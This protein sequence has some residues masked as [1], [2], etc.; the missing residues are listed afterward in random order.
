MN[1]S[2]ARRESLAKTT[3]AAIYTADLEIPGALWG[4]T[5]RSECARGRIAG[6]DFDPA[7]PWVECTVVTPADIPGDNCVAHIV[8]DQ[9]CLAAT[10]INHWGEPLLLIAHPDRYMAEAARSAV[11]VRYEPAEALLD[12]EFSTP[13]WRP[14]RC[15]ACARSR[16]CAVRA[17]ILCRSF[18]TKRLPSTTCALPP[19]TGVR[20]R[21]TCCFASWQG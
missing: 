8:E 16:S 14:Y 10:E 18:P 15:V 13:A 12:A 1:R 17:S 7:F 6:F 21:E 20:L 11:R 4:V 19:A 9:P 3:G 2:V 5:V